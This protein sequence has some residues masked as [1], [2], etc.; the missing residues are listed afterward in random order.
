M[1][2]V[3]HQ[4]CKCAEDSSYDFRSLNTGVVTLINY[5]SRIPPRVSQL[6]LAHE[7]GH[8]FGSPVMTC[9]FSVSTFYGHLC[10][11]FLFS[12]ITL[13]NVSLVYLMVTT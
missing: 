8:N 7:I 2:G 12:M 4:H 1:G 3:C 13:P 11:H 10:S 6:T 5:G 9:S